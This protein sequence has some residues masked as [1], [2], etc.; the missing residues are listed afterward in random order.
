M[1]NDYLLVRGFGSDWYY[2]K[3]K[4][5]ILPIFLEISLNTW[6][7]IHGKVRPLADFAAVLAYFQDLR[8]FHKNFNITG[9]ISFCECIQ[10]Y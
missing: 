4:A 5:E 3:D 6:L 7:L 1:N 9:S 8:A 2:S 10:Q